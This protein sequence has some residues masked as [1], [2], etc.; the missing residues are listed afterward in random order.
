M[1]ARRWLER[2]RPWVDR[3]VL[4]PV[5]LAVETV[6]VVRVR[7]EIAFVR[8]RARV[9]RRFPAPIV[10]RP[11]P[12][13]LAVLTHV[14]GP[15]T[16]TNDSAHRLEQ[17]LDGLLE[18][19]GHTRLELVLNTLPDRHV[20]ADLPE[21]LRSRLVVREQHDVE[22][23]FLGF[24][25]QDELV[26]RA[27]DADWFLYLEDDLVLG[28]SFFLEK[29]EYFNA[30]APARSVLLPNRYELW[31]G[32]KVYIDQWSRKRDFDPAWG[33]LTALELGDWKFAEFVNP[34]SGCYCL[35]HAQLRR[36]LATGRQW[37]G[38][39]SYAGPRE[40]AATGS[41][42]ECFRLYKPHPDNSHFLEI[43]HQGTKYAELY[44]QVH[45]LESSATP[46]S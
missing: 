24:R 1:L 28:D 11:G 34:H 18:S 44:S 6:R 43:R 17:T 29:L 15:E 45:D 3:N 19:L 37:Y 32:R 35:S 31:Q 9:H 30:G 14:A 20:A 39:A 40:G 41:L 10:E 4:A 7:S 25:G 23:L 2:A 36:W 5:G 46:Q 33:R 22:P 27:E 21:H 8:Q 42:E 12:R 16:E 38:L 26:R 13:V